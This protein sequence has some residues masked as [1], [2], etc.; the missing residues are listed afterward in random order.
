MQAYAFGK[1]IECSNKFTPEWWSISP[2]PTWDWYNVD[3]R[4]RVVE[5]KP[6]TYYKVIYKK[7]GTLQAHITDGYYSSLENFHKFRGNTTATDYIFCYLD[8][9]NTISD[10]PQ[11]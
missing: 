11:K 6:T 10:T 3:Y 8:H 9:T 2:N 7:K 4:I 1:D 5:T